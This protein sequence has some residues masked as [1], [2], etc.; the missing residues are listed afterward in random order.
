VQAQPLGLVAHLKSRGG[1]FHGAGVAVPAKILASRQPGRAGGNLK[2]G[3]GVCSSF[4]VNQRGGSPQRRS[5]GGTSWVELLIGEGLAGWS[6]Q[7]WKGRRGAPGRGGARGGGGR[8][9][10][11]SEEASAGGI[12]TAYGVD[13]ASS[14]RAV[15]CGSATGLEDGH[16][17]R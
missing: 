5:H 3:S 11:C 12:F 8:A 10:R 7:S 4:E 15:L 1:E 17:W 9:E 6:G 14:L 13:D 2:Q 16:T